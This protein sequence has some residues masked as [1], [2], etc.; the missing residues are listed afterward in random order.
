MLISDKKWEEFDFT[1]EDEEDEKGVFICKR[2][3]RHI[4]LNQITGN[5]AYISSSKKNNGIDNYITPPDYMTIYINAMT[6]NNSGSVGYCF[7]HP[8]KFVCSD[9]C[10]VIKIKDT[11]VILNNYIALFLKPIIESMKNKYNFGRE[12]SDKR[13]I[14]EKIEL[15]IN[16]NNKP[17]WIYMEN[18]IKQLST[19]IIFNKKIPK[20]F[21]NNYLNNVK[22][23]SFPIFELFE[24]IGTKTTSI[25]KLEK[26]GKG[27]YPYITTKATDNGTEGLFDYYTEDGNVL[28]IDSAVLGYC[29][30]QPINFS[31]SDHVEKLIP[32]FKL[33]KHIALFLTTIINLEQFRYS[34]GR[35]YNQARI[36]NTVI[37]LP[38]KDN[39]PDWEFMENYIKDLPYSNWI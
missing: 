25:R 22:Y 27:D 17:D 35:K 33:N 28:T 37:E 26:Y 4:R 8:Y 39:K 34:Y 38:S 31:A 6:I 12:I 29:S 36:K 16:D 15:P 32:K 19:K 5:I 21:G 18:Y 3:R 10:T 11:T 23:Q 2:G 30:Y 20:Y 24:I 9:H 14:H 13:M 7:Y 1:S